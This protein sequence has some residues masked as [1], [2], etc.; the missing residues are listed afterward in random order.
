MVVGQIRS[1]VKSDPGLMRYTPFNFALRYYPSWLGQD[2]AL[3]RFHGRGL[4]VGN[5]L[6]G[7]FLHV[8]GHTVAQVV[9]DIA[10]IG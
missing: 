5:K 4:G 1:M 9:L 6:A 7:T 10:V 8:M 3:K 2:Y